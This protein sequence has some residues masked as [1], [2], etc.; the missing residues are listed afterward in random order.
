MANEPDPLDA[1]RTDVE[2]AARW[3]WRNLQGWVRKWAG[4]QLVKLFAGGALSIGLVWT[5]LPVFA[6]AFATAVVVLL[7]GYAIYVRKQLVDERTMRRWAFVAN[8]RLQQ[9]VVKRDL[10][11]AQATLIL[12]GEPRDRQARFR[13]HAPGSREFVAAVRYLEARVA[14]AAALQHP[15]PAKTRSGRGR[16]SAR[17]DV[18]G[19]RRR[20][21]VTKAEIAKLD[22][23]IQALASPDAVELARAAEEAVRSYEEQR[24]AAHKADRVA[25]DRHR[26][27][28]RPTEAVG[29]R[30]IDV[31]IGPTGARGVRRRP[32]PLTPEQIARGEGPPGRAI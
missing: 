26:A 2:Q 32:P 9:D 10:A 17:P 5:A 13:I 29:P 28:R 12:A 14:D 4:V 24:A 25:R 1:L 22:A 23:Q 20:R 31:A 30:T 15:Q 21:E 8:K 27:G 19:V 6:A 16:R 3:R 7:A 18:S 11:L